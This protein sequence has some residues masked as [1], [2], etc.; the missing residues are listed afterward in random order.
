MTVHFAFV[1]ISIMVEIYLE[2]EYFLF[3]KEVKPATSTD[4][5]EKFEFQNDDLRT[6]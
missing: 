1:F 6:N 5:S 2:D 3:L 4:L